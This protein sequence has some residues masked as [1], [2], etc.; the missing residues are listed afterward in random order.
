MNYQ[1]AIVG[2]LTIFALF[3]HVL[4]G[5]R[6]SLS[7]E[8][9]KLAAKETLENFET[10]ERNWVQAMCTFQLVTIDLLALSVLLFLLAFTDVFIQKQLVGFVLSTFYF[11]WGCSWLVQLFVFKRKASDYLL[12]GHWAFW[13]GCSGLIFWGASSL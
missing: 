6:E 1:F 4:V 11:L 9:A 2:V 10:L 7:V 12:L 8:P 13:F 5:I 3:A